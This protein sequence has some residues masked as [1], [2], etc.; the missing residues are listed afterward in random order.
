MNT[1]T[2]RL[3]DSQRDRVENVASQR[4]ETIEELVQEALQTYL[5]ELEDAE[6]VRDFEARRAAGDVELRDW[7]EFEAELDAEELS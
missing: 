1:L 7:A 5:E 4:G 6:I 3:S 2:I